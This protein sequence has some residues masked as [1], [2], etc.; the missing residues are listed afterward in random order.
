MFL[1]ATPQLPAGENA[2][3]T[4][5]HKGTGTIVVVDDEEVVRTTFTHILQL[6][7]Y[8]VQCFNDGREALD[9]FAQELSAKRT[10][11]ALIFDLTIPGGMGG[12]EAGAEIRKQNPTIPIFVASGYADDSVMRNPAAYG[13]TGSIAKPFSIEDLS[14]M[15]NTNL[16]SGNES[17]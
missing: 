4:D 9:F 6:Q 16:K 10:I 1:P 17:G 13:F 5:L 3:V 7:G 14:A 2:G 12:R 15:L 8:T 11:T